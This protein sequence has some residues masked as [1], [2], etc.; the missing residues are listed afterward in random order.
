MMKLHLSYQ[1]VSVAVAAGL[2]SMFF[3]L[4]LNVAKELGSLVYKCLKV[5]LL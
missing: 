4:A 5:F 1:K 2:M 3:C